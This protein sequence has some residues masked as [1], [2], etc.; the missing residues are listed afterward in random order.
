MLDPKQLKIPNIAPDHPIGSGVIHMRQ[1]GKSEDQLGF[2]SITQGNPT[3]IDFTPRT[4]N[5]DYTLTLES[6]DPDWWSGTTAFCTDV[7]KVKILGDYEHLT[8][9]PTHHSFDSNS[10]QSLSIDNVVPVHV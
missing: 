10:P 7:I 6:F 4:K 9:I 1:A 3:I 8:A 5:G 2:V